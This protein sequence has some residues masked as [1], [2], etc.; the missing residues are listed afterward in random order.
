[1]T[2]TNIKIKN[3]KKELETIPVLGGDKKCSF[4]YG[5]RV[6]F[7]IRIEDFNFFKAY[8]NHDISFLSFYIC[9]TCIKTF[10]KNNEV[11]KLNYNLGLI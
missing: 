8:L 2:I 3:L 5:D 10:N 7:Y 1:M 6:V 11:F 4:C 9:N